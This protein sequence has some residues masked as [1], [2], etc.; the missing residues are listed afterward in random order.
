MN[1]QRRVQ[2]LKGQGRVFLP[3]KTKAGRRQIK[4]GQ[5]V[6]AQLAAHRERQVSQKDIAGNRWEENELIFPNTIGKP[7]EN[8]KL[9][10]DFNRL[11]LKNNLPNIR[12]HDLR[13]TSISF[14]L[15][16][17]TPVNTVQQR[18]GHSKASVTTDTYGHLMALSQV[19]A[20]ENIE[21]F[22]LSV[23]GRSQA[24]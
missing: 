19:E 20:A 5:G 11:L 18:A 21:D 1:V 23:A 17:G 12:F 8:T 10:H 2:R 7:I 16:M 9:I 14:L 22:V 4:L 13:H 6:L 15:D 24:K 3:P